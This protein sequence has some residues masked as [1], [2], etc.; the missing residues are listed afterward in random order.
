[1]RLAFALA[2]AIATFPYTIYAQAPLTTLLLID[3]AAW[4]TSTF[5]TLDWSH[6]HDHR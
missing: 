6:D 4:L 2:L 3:T 5:L 1:M